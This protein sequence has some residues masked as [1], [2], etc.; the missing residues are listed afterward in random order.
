MPMMWLATDTTRPT[1]LQIRAALVLY[2]L[3]LTTARII[4]M[5]ERISPTR[6]ISNP[7]TMAKMPR[8]KAGKK[9]GFFPSADGWVWGLFAWKIFVAVM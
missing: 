1:M 7:R 6:G 8:T 2:S 5:M 3:R 4:P 9:L